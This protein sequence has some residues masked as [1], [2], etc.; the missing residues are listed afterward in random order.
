MGEVHI[1]NL[2]LVPALTFCKT[3]DSFKWEEV[4]Y[5]DFRNVEHCDPFTMLI[6]GLKLKTMREEH[7]M[8]YPAATSRAYG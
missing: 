7:D 1:P 6:T 4:N 5:F 8:K 3:L 2:E